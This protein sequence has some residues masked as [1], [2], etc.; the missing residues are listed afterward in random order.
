M[1]DIP[2]NT[3]APE[4]ETD[5]SFSTVLGEAVKN[6]F[7]F[8]SSHKE[9][10][11][12][13][14]NYD[15]QSSRENT[16]ELDRISNTL[17]KDG[18]KP[19]KGFLDY[20]GD[21]KLRIRDSLLT[22]DQGTNSVILRTN[23]KASTR[24]NFQ[25]R[26]TADPVAA[27][28]LSKSIRL[29]PNQEDGVF[30]ELKYRS[31]EHAGIVKDPSKYTDKEAQKMS[32]ALI[33]AIKDGHKVN[34]G[35]ALQAALKQHH[36]KALKNA[37]NTYDTFIKQKSPKRLSGSFGKAAERAKHMI[38]I[39]NKLKRFDKK[40]FE[41]A[42]TADAAEM[43]KPKDKAEN[44]QEPKPKDKPKEK[45]EP[46]F[47]TAQDRKIFAGKFED[48]EFKDSAN[49]AAPFFAVQQAVRASDAALRLAKGET[50][51]EIHETRTEFSSEPPAD[52][53]ALG[54]RD[55]HKTISEHEAASDADSVH[56]ISGHLK[57]I[58]QSFEMAANMYDEAGKPDV[59]ARVRALGEKNQELLIEAN[60]NNVAEP[61][62]D[63]DAA[64]NP[65]AQ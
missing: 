7:S 57:E 52:P 51:P 54:I 33:A 16:A 45:E 44:K 6:L 14:A 13:L 27:D 21:I 4:E 29:L 37:V 11:Q 20:T 42:A 61:D 35:K 22:V 58:E 47:D 34:N 19:T 50:D 49:A 36:P 43:K 56:D 48:S 28:G 53:R 25:S 31:G 10:T 55:L 63:Q 30:L 60:A 12:L 40:T 23:D 39:K 46:K 32:M 3:N 59:A 9:L 65:D 18:E 26:N 1:S 5:I 62:I 41:D 38:G 64:P 17:P 8:F 24:K 15:P 2:N